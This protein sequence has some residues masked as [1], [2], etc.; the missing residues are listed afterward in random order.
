MAQSTILAAGN[1][2]A[3]STDVVVAAGA[4]VVIGLF[5]ATANTLISSG[6]ITGGDA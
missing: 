1:T 6:L 5:A 4:Y 2:A 3:T